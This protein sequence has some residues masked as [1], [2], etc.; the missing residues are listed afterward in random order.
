MELSDAS[1]VLAGI[2]FLSL[3]TIESGGALML[4][5]V[6]GRQPATPLQRSFFRAGHAHAG[7]FVDPRPDLP[8][9]SSTPPTLDGRA[10]LGG[11]LVHPRRRHCSA[12][13]VLPVGDPAAAPPTPTVSCVLRARRRRR[14][15][16]SGCVT[17]GI[18][19]LTA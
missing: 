13:R 10:R 3:V 17:L 2:L 15:W 11:P 12:R 4:R 14:A 9:A 19:L 6:R 18:G 8:G 16:P 5:V 1:Q 7:M